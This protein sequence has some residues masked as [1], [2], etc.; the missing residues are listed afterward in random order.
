MSGLVHSRLTDLAPALARPSKRLASLIAGAESSLH[1]EA[2]EAVG[3]GQIL[4]GSVGWADAVIVVTA[5][6]I[7]VQTSDG[8]IR[9]FQLT[10]VTSLSVDGN[11]VVV[12]G[13]GAR[14]WCTSP[15][16]GDLVA[17]AASH[18]LKATGI[19]AHRSSTLADALSLTV[20]ACTVLGGS[21]PWTLRAGDHVSLVFSEGALTVEKA[22]VVVVPPTSYGALRA[23]DLD[24]RGEV[25]QGGGFVGGGFGLEGILGGIALAAV[26]NAATTSTS[27]ETVL[28]VE[29]DDG[30]LILAHTKWTPVQ[31]RITL[32][33][34]FMA[35]R[36]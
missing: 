3:A 8:T 18:G 7:Y 27:V 24:G 25:Q 16:A 34:V 28:R 30:E 11:T 9:D 6:R 14:I 19:P 12:D 15:Q 10:E 2:P 31:L 13:E 17:A 20:D 35:M 23:L 33:E 21:G 32:S 1:G 26:L 4:L 22:G 5:T 29:Y 36:R